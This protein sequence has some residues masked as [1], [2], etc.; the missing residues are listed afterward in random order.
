MSDSIKETVPK[1]IKTLWDI[2]NELRSAAQNTVFL[3]RDEARQHL[4]D[5]RRHLDAL[6]GLAQSRSATESDAADT[7]DQVPVPPSIKH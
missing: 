7:S 4:S 3:R 1:L 5:A 2:E 6:L